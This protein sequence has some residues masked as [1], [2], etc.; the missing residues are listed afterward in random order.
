MDS[1]NELPTV[2][3]EASCSTSLDEAVNDVYGSCF[4]RDEQAELDMVSAIMSTDGQI[5]ILG[6]TIFNDE[7]F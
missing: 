6:S 5:E 2:A 4:L 1:L 3:A 7:E